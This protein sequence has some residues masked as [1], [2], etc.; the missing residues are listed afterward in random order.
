MESESDN[1]VKIKLFI[2]LKD[3]L[4]QIEKL[5]CTFATKVVLEK[6]E[7]ESEYGVGN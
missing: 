5:A 6:V 3:K 4:S 7:N 2:G 1:G